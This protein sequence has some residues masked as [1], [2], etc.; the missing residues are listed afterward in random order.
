MAKFILLD[1]R[2]EASFIYFINCWV[3]KNLQKYVMF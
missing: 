3:V 2:G 1:V